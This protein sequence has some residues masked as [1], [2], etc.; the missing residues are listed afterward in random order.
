MSTAPAAGVRIAGAR[1]VVTGAA[2]GIGRAVAERLRAEGAAVV[3]LDLRADPETVA[4]DVR[5]EGSV[6]AGFAEAV[7][8]L[9]GA[10][11]ILVQSAGVFPVRPLDEVSVAE[12]RDTF[13]VNVLGTMLC[14][15]TAVGLARAAGH[16]L[17]IVNLSS[18][19]A[20]SSDWEEPCAA[21]AATKAG[22]GALTRAMAGEWAPYG[23]RVNAVAPGMIDTPMLRVMD[24]PA[25]GAETIRSSV[26]LARL[27]RAEEI[28][29][30][31]C[32]LASEGASYV[33][34]TTVTADGGYRIR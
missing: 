10:P 32:F 31:V 24:D 12:W 14:A 26:P 8:R 13:D 3:G 29:S 1:A 2:S 22:V 17:S 30:V 21:Y 19:A 33:T 5:D 23:V 7:S 16:G 9:G 18:I 6:R 27:G 25:A 4:V 28:A 34:G 11:T 20:E 15:R